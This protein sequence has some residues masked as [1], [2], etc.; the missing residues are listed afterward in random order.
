MEQRTGIERKKTSISIEGLTKAKS[1]LDQFTEDCN[2]ERDKAG[3][4]KSFEFCYEL[5]WKLLKKV[6]LNQGVDLGSPKDCF[7]EAAINKL[8]RDPVIWFKFLDMRNRTVHTYDLDVLEDI[9]KILPAF[10]K[11]VSDL[12]DVLKIEVKEEDL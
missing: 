11:E 2:T 6:L 8:I 12:L 9:M 7:R 1:M 3:V 5:S 10:K 4:I